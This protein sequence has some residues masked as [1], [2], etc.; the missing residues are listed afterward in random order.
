MTSREKERD[1][2]WKGPRL[3]LEQQQ[4]GEKRTW[5]WPSRQGYE[6][7]EK[8]VDQVEWTGETE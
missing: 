4:E 6:C 1:A 2:E 8:L 3:S 5:A 7:Q